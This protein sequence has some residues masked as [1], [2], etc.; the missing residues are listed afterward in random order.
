MAALID[1]PQRYFE[2]WGYTPSF[3]Q[4]LFQGNPS[5][6]PDSKGI[7]IDVVFWSVLYVQLPAEFMGLT[8]DYA[9]PEQVDTIY[10]SSGYSS[11][12][13]YH[14]Y[15]LWGKEYEGYIVAMGYDVDENTRPSNEPSKW[16]LPKRPGIPIVR[17]N[18]SNFLLEGLLPLEMPARYW[19]EL[20]QR[21]GTWIRNISLFAEHP[22]E[23]LKNFLEGV[24]SGY[25]QDSPGSD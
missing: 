24:K 9:L 11:F 8:M 1:Y 12:T 13:Q 5:R 22:E 15:R 7:R 16:D 23:T 3:N 19:T 17:E 20:G 18:L 4:L 14:V 25:M 6:S 21:Y 2:L 10:Q